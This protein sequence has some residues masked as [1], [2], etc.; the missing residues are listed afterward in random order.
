MRDP[1]SRQH[2]S[3]A[4]YGSLQEVSDSQTSCTPHHAAVAS[5]L[6]PKAPT[7]TFG[8]ITCRA[9]C[10]ADQEGTGFKVI[11]VSRAFEGKTAKRREKLVRQV[12]IISSAALQSSARACVSNMP[13]RN[14]IPSSRQIRMHLLWLGKVWLMYTRQRC[15]EPSLSL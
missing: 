8:H 10:E 9:E 11:V 13:L 5:R 6:C 15:C 3:A 4:G 12:V 1:F 14:S 7:H 2:R